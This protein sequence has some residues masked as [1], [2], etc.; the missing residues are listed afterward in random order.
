MEIF[1]LQV[2]YSLPSRMLGRHRSSS[3]RMWA[4]VLETLT[5]AGIGLLG[6]DKALRGFH[7]HRLHLKGRR[8]PQSNSGVSL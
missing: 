2:F 5:E 7:F 3:W 1:V 4:A 6:I 8:H